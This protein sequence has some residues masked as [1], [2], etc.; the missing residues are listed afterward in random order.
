MKRDRP[1]AS[2]WW[3]AVVLGLLVGNWLYWAF[4]R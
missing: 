3:S 4:V 2:E 1:E